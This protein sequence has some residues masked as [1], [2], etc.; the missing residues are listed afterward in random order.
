MST[1]RSILA[2]TDFSVSAATAAHRAAQLASEHAAG[3]DLL[4]VVPEKLL[5]DF[6]EILPLLGPLE[7]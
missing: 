4:H 7:Q 6:R 1:I 5:T 2:A 3:L